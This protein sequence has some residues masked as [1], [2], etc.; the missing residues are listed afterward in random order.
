[1]AWFT[2]SIHP[3]VTCCGLRH[4]VSNP[5]QVRH[6]VLGHRSGWA[7]SPVKQ[8]C[9]GRAQ[10]ADGIEKGANGRKGCAKQ[11]VPRQATDTALFDQ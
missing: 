10:A 7:S 1:M 9:I 5:Y 8:V 2:K 4:V 6:A 3:P 11:T